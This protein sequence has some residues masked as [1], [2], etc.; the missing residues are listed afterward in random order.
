MCPSR[1]FNAR[2]GRRVT[3]LFRQRD[4]PRER[5][6]PSVRV[7]RG[8]VD[9][10]VARAE[11]EGAEADAGGAAEEVLV[12]DEAGAAEGANLAVEDL[13]RGRVQRHR[14]DV[15]RAGDS[16]RLAREPERVAAVPG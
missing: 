5:S 14:P 2:A 6:D 15:A 1:A 8:E 12:D 7:E 13:V 11:E 16:G 4:D 9:R 3:P 10:V